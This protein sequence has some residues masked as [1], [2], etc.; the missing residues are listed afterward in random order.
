MNSPQVAK[1]KAALLKLSSD[2]DGKQFIKDLFTIDALQ[3][4]TDAEYDVLREVVKAV[5]PGLLKVPTPAV[6]P[7]K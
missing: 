2:P 7:T 6:T 5:D 1:L 3:E 4:A